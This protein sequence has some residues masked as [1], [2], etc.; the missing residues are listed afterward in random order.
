V[1]VPIDAILAVASRD[2]RVANKRSRN[3]FGIPDVPNEPCLLLC[4]YITM[5]ALLFA[6]QAFAASSLTSPEHLFR[7]RIAPGQKQLPVPLKE[8]LAEIPL[9]RRCKSTVHCVQIS[10]DEALADH[11]LRSQMINLGSMTGMELPTGPYTFR[12]GNGQALDN[13]SKKTLTF[14]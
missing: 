14:G 12:R 9:F 7:L 1:G 8:E 3:E 6:D 13:S 10:E 2:V 11:T 5:L 4:P